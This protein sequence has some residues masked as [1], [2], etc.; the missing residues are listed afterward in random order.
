MKKFI[1]FILTYSFAAFAGGF[2]PGTP[3]GSSGGGYST[4][5]EDGASLT[6]RTTV[7]FT[8]SSITCSDSGG[9]TVCAVSSGS[10]NF[11]TFTTTFGNGGLST[12][13][14]STTTVPA[15]WVGATSSIILTP[16]CVATVGGN[17]VDNCLV[18][19]ISCNVTSI[20]ASTSFDVVC[21]SPVD[22]HGGYTISYTGG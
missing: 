2:S 15:T 3:P 9:I 10:G 6:Q 4:I 17:T 8:G 22:A 20:T 18:S 21:N 7:N 19:R 11:G 13:E 1:L 12:S 16:K 5:Q 14:S